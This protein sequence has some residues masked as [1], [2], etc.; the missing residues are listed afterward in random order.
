MQF[1]TESRETAARLPGGAP[2]G[3]VR[4]LS[5]P[6]EFQVG[7]RLDDLPLQWHAFRDA[8]A[9]PLHH[10]N[11]E[12]FGALYD[13]H[14]RLIIDSE[15]PTDTREWTTNPRWLPSG[16]VADSIR[17]SGRSFFGG[18]YFA[19]FGHFLVETLP[20]F[21][22]DIDYGEYDH[23]VVYRGAAPPRKP[24][25]RIRPVERELFAALGTTA[26]KIF[27]LD[28]QPVVFDEITVSTPPFW[29]KAIADPR[30]VGVHDRI[31][32]IF[33]S[34][35]DRSGVPAA[36]RL[37]LSRTRLLESRR[38]AV[39][40]AAIEQLMQARGFAIIHPQLLTIQEQVMLMRTAEVI[41]GCDGSALHLST[42]ARPGTR[43]V[44]I[45]GRAVVNQFII[46]QARG[47]DAI[48]VLAAESVLG[49]R[50]K[51]WSADLDR[52]NAALDLLDGELAEQTP[53]SSPT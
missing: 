53:R 46:D 51:A 50:A 26:D 28:E 40:E 25:L 45:D 14:G 41:A 32:R 10:T 9:L 20:R 49:R 44:A 4:L 15:R 33:E 5:Y 1:L 47:L 8:V 29:E 43:L 17:L 7:D 34:R 52:I 27:I 39:N 19:A 24:Q 18:H 11:R 42:F 30:F 37:Y 36:R 21:W 16:P 35:A 38:A 23:I 13:R 3:T 2:V 12:R 48:H 31:G 6:D 22:P